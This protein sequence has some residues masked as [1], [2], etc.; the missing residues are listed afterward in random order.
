VPGTSKGGQ[1]YLPAFFS[2]I[3]RDLRASRS[4]QETLSPPGREHRGF[5]LLLA[6]PF[7]SINSAI[8]RNCKNSLRAVF[9]YLAVR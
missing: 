6:A 5:L 4:K 3:Y 9:L 7:P 8:Y 1:N 2:F